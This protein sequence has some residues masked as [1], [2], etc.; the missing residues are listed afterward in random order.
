MMN[1]STSLHEL[2]PRNKVARGV[3]LGAVASGALAIG[4]LSSAGAAT[5]TCASISGIGN[6]ADCTSTPTSFAVGLGPGTKAA[7]VGLFD[8]AVAVGT[9]TSAASV[10]LG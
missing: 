8:G 7:G 1:H 4:A 9:N 2:I 10:G 6:S 5:A 3:V